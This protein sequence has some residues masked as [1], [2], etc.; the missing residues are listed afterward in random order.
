MQEK[1]TGKTVWTAGAASIRAGGKNR[2]W[3][4]LSVRS[5]LYRRSAGDDGAGEG[6]LLFSHVLFINK[7]YLGE[8]G[9]DDI[10]A[11][12][13]NFHIRSSCAGTQHCRH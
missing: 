6:E 4:P 8:I 11:L 3:L 9:I 10:Y 7:R 2:G 1:N 12:H 5:L 13:D